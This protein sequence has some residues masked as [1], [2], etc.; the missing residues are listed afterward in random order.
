MRRI[1][2]I[3]TPIIQ[4]AYHISSL[5]AVPSIGLAYL[6]AALGKADFAVAIVDAAGE[7]LTRYRY[8]KNS[9]WTVNGLNADEIIERIPKDVEAILAS[10]S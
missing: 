6:K 10:H 2:L 3:R 5:R 4:P 1:A 9:R 8:I 7:G